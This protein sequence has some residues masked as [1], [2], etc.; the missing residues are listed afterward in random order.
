MPRRSSQCVQGTASR[1]EKSSGDCIRA[2]DSDSGIY[3]KAFADAARIEFHAR[4]IEGHGP[5]FPIE[6]DMPP[7]RDGTKGLEFGSWRDMS[8]MI[9]GPTVMSN[10]PL[11]TLLQCWA[12]ARKSTISASVVTGPAAAFR[13]TRESSL[14]SR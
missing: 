5:V 7:A 11:L 12:C 4:S 14:E 8:L 3:R 10:M 2:Y 9:S 6:F 1:G 13:L